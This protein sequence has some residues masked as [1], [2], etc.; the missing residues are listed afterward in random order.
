MHLKYS[1]YIY[2]NDKIKK[3][4]FTKQYMRIESRIIKFWFLIKEQ[5][6][7]YLICTVHNNLLS[8]KDN[9]SLTLRENFNVYIGYTNLTLIIKYFIEYLKFL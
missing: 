9:R 2:K 1:S 6:L 7:R 3:S 4:E 8:F 5:D